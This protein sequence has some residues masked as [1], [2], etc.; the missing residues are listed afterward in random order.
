MSKFQPVKG[1][2]DFWPGEMIKRQFVSDIM[3]TVAEK[4]GFLPM[5]TPALESFELLAAKGGGGEAI[6]KEIY[7]FKDQGDRELG[8][9]F[10]L[11]VPTCRVIASK[12]DL[13]LP[14][15]RYQTGS[16]WRYDNPQAGRYRQ[17]V[18]FD[19]DIFGTT[20]PESDAEIIAATCDVFDN[21]GFEDFVIRLNNK[22]L[23]EAF[24][25]SVG[26]KD[27]VDV[28]RSIDKLDKIGPEGVRKELKEKLNDEKK[29]EKVLEFIKT[30]GDVGVLDK[31][32][33][34]VD[35]ELGKTAI[36]ELREIIDFVKAFGYDKN[37]QI[38]L[39]LIRG[40]EYY[41][42]TVIEVAV[43]GGKLA[44]AGGGRYDKMIEQFGGR[45]TPAI[46]LAFGFERIVDT[47]IENNMIKVEPTVKLFVVSIND[48]VRKDA[49]KICQR[50]RREGIPSDFDV[51]GKDLRKQLSYASSASIPFVLFVGE[52]ELK[53]KKFKLK[54][55]ACG[56]EKTASLEQLVKF[57]KKS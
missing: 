55:M 8:L 23:I 50:F 17:F 21:L 9:R 6:K 42:G 30:K 11:T 44:L 15:K 24:I 5:D 13:P 52:K 3:R 2:R 26:I 14:F 46:G 56:E 28:F 39:S 49:L 10:D 27:A 51:A 25:Q 29:I 1:M 19:L 43:G 35:T 48:I 31:I 54:D 4:W 7:Y 33:K 12:L 34:I 47:M 38:D 40:L 20:R 37:V 18:Q 57:L 22:K 53:E 41:T 32:E 16:V 36:K 45:A